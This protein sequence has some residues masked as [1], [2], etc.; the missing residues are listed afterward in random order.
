MNHA[1]KMLLISA[2]NLAKLQHQVNDMT[3]PN[4]MNA[5]D[6]EM[7]H[8]INQKGEN[9]YDKW[10]E[11]DQVMRKYMS[12]YKK[13]KE[14]VHIP[15]DTE[16]LQS[17]LE[18]PDVAS[19]ILQSFSSGHPYRKK[20]DVLYNIL[21][22]SSAITWDDAGRV[23]INGSLIPGSNLTDLFNDVI[24]QR[25]S[26]SPVG[27]EAFVSLLA[28]LNIPKEY[29]GNQKRWAYIQN[30]FLEPKSNQDVVLKSPRQTRNVRWQ[31]YKR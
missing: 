4:A 31:P 25:Q 12:K 16:S 6:K 10:L 5:L 2:E 21:K 14:P 27:W 29:I 9:D 8:I 19:T 18:K 15:V 17:A 23:S 30:T 20:A 1:R 11:Y 22:N 28:S 26:S 3:V 7:W 24:R 13:L